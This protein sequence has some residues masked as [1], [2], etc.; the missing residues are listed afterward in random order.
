[1]S[2][3]KLNSPAGRDVRLEII[4]GD[5]LDILSG[6]PDESAQCVVTSPP[7][8]GLRDY[9][10]EGQLGL[11]KTPEEYVAKMVEVFHEVRRVL[12]KDGTLWL[13]MGDG[14]SSGGRAK[15]RSGASSNKGHL[16]QNELPRPKT[17]PGLKPKDLIGMPW[18]L[19]L[20]LQADGWWL[21]QD[22]IWAKPNPMPESVR[23]RCTKSHEY[24]FL[25]TKSARYYYDHVAI[26]E[27]CGS[28]THPRISRKAMKQKLG[29]QQ[30]EAG[31][32]PKCVAP[33]RGIKQNRSFAAACS[34]PALTRNKRSVWTVAIQPFP[35]AHFAT[36][37]ENLI[38]PCILA[39]SR[40][41]DTV[42]DPFAGS[43]TVGAVSKRLGRK[44]VGIEL[45][46]QYCE[47]ARERIRAA[48]G[49]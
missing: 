33:G 18:R 3:K 22:I 27:P 46:P 47:M 25:L 34:M 6:I 12:C 45:N 4:Q 2:D 23:D 10:V 49:P 41:R 8:W 19:A 17:P 5:A 16:I 44:F 37:P 42:C 38:E 30:I 20:A 28:N 40:P 43:G 13:N 15:Y 1:M 21:R 26:M 31:A 35:G 39:G 9:G 11:E 24:I 29:G 36:F 7:Y 48:A 32:N 14:Y